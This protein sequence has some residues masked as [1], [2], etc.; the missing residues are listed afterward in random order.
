MRRLAWA[1]FAFSS[2]GLLCFSARADQP[3]PPVDEVLRRMVE[4]A[5]ARSAPQ[6]ASTYICRKKT[7]TEEM[8]PSGRVTERKVKVGESRPASNGATDANKWGSQNG[9]NLGED[10]LRRFDFDVVDRQIINRRATLILT[11]VPKRPAVP[12]F[13]LQDF[14]LNRAMGTIWVDEQQYEVVK[15]D[16]RLG[17]PISFGP[18]GAV[19]EVSFAFERFFSPDGGWLT[20]WT[21]TFVKARKLLKP[22]QMR[23]R[24][25][26]TDFRKLTAAR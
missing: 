20:R 2:L 19:N 1:L 13:H 18:L 16:I 3:L 6:T 25:D 15:A 22:I 10:L 21:E 24:V 9:V 12:A 7:V 14:V 11:F 23:K 17:Q 5:Q 26:C 8:D 4:R